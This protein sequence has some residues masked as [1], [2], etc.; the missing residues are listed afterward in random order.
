MINWFFPLSGRVLPAPNLAY[1]DSGGSGKKPKPEIQPRD[2]KWDLAR[3]KHHFIKAQSL[4]VWGILDLAGM[5]Y[6]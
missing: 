6:G 4:K 2:G 1:L 3:T 5:T